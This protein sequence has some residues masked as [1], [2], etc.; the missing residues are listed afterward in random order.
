MTSLP[1]LDQLLAIEPTLERTVPPDFI[2]LNGHMNIG[3]YLE[4]GSTGIWRLAQTRL[5]M[6]DDYIPARGMS[7]FTVEQHLTYL[8]ELRE[9]ELV[10]V[11][12]RLLDAGDKALHLV[13]LIVDRTHGR[14]A[15]VL[16]S[17]LVHV[18]MATRR[19]TPFPPDVAALVATEVAADREL[20]WD[21]P[22]S[23]TMGVRR[24]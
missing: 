16:E 21:P 24:G 20:G 15:C 22:L 11:H 3:R 17:S 19:A 13:A 9:G 7:T 4:I 12:P 1:T 10:S 6:T 14:L 5:G 23:G 2:D 18:D 8:S